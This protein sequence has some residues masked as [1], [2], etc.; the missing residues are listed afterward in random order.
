MSTPSHQIFIGADGGGSGCR[1]AIGT[2]ERILGT[3]TGG[4]ANVA[5][6]PVQAVE[7]L[8]ETILQAAQGAEVDLTHAQA[9][10][11]LAGIMSPADASRVA[12]ALP[13]RATVTDDRL[14][15]LTGALQGDGY[16]LAIGTGSFVAASKGGQHRFIGGWGFNIGDQASGARLGHAALE[17]TLL[18]H[19]GVG[20]HTPLTQSLL[21]EFDRD[22]AKITAFSLNAT[23]ADYAQ[24]APQVAHSND[25]L[26]RD[27][28]TQGADYLA[29]ALTALGFRP[30]EPLCLTGGL[31]PAYRTYLPDSAFQDPKGT[32]L[33]GAFHLARQ[34]QDS[35]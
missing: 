9:H 12:Q 29:R 19:D 23:P 26:A 20:V 2:Q 28:M 22:P 32:A 16:L 34:A 14:T 3:A 10:I 17:Q 11:G 24:F 1:V 18:A 13:F 5:S 6:N 25:P 33:D 27:L 7:T 4:P 15:S 30:G 31:G 35:P 21:A 8:K